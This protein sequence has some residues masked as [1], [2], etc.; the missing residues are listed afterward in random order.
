[1]TDLHHNV[2]HHLN[3]KPKIEKEEFHVAHLHW[4]HEAL[5]MGGHLS[6][7]L[8]AKDAAKFGVHEEVDKVHFFVF[9]M[10]IK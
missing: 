4:T 10:M 7:K 5:Q 8:S 9:F 2:C 3:Y 1:M 6:T